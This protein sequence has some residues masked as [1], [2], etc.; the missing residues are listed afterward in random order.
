MMSALFSPAILVLDRLKYPFKFGLIFAVVLVPL[1]V[2]S[3]LL[4]AEFGEKIRFMNNGRDGL[5]YI[6]VVRRLTEHLARHRSLGRALRAGD[7]DQRSSLAAERTAIDTALAALVATDQRL[8]AGLNTQDAVA[9]VQR[10]WRAL[11]AADAAAANQSLD[12]HNTLIAA[13]LGLVGRVADAS[14]LTLDPQLDSYYLGDALVNR[15][16]PLI[17]AIGLASEL[18]AG[19]AADGLTPDISLRLAVLRHD[20]Q[21]LG[22]GLQQALQAAV[23]ANPELQPALGEA[24][25]TADGAIADFATAL[26]AQLGS[27]AASAVD[28]AA[29]AAVAGAYRLHDA[30]APELDGLFVHRIAQQTRIGRS[31]IAVAIGV[32]VAVSYLFT[33]LYLSVRRSIARIGVVTGQLAGG[34]LTA[35]VTL[36]AR[37][38]MSAIA[39]SF[40][41]MSENFEGS[42]RQVVGSTVQLAAAAAEELATVARESARNVGRQRSETDQVATA[43]HQMSATVREVANH[44]NTAADAAHQASDRSRGGK[45]VV[46]QAAQTI[47]QLAE[48]VTGASGVIQG[49][50]QDSATIGMVL[51]VINNVAEQTNLLALNAAI[52]AAR[53][54]EHGRGFAVVADE[55]R[56]LAS[57]TRQSTQEIEDM[58]GRLQTGVQNAVAAMA[59]TQEQAQDGARQARDAATAMDAITDAVAIINDM[60][61]QV[62]SAAEEQSAVSEEISR[63]V[64]AIS[65]IS[66]E[67][68]A[69]TEQTTA[70]SGELAR[71]AAD[72]QQLVGRFKIREATAE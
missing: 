57:R 40:N 26:D 62:A 6:A 54:G 32:L 69:G 25:A 36:T 30:I 12:A 11:E 60:N 47:V 42:I 28:G 71:L 24:L 51:A 66:E 68:A 44:T 49:V 9:E 15:L 29:A 7:E 61:T 10:Q 17:D 8:G 53:A 39:R 43:V 19:G 70:A 64:T 41:A 67:T 27:D 35:R 46:E 2:L 23:T 48:G 5:A 56:T 52:E 21:Q 16:P 63:N 31:A 58:I 20:I 72:L 59:L 33:A 13:L 50:A 4:I 38:E 3:G 37:D 14:E 65:Q 55:V 18:T 45:L 1:L 34:D 22:K